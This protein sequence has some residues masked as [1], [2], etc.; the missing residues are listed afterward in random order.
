MTAINIEFTAH[1]HFAYG[2]PS[3]IPTVNDDDD[4]V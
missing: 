1:W 4:D 3:N 2:F